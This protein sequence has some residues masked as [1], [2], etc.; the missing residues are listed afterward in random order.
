MVQI[1]EE[2]IQLI[3]RLEPRGL[4]DLVVVPRVERVAEPSEHPG[5]AQLVLSVA[6]EGGGVENDRAVGTL[7]YVSPPQVP[8][9]QGGEHLHVGK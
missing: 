9:K 2:L 3:P 4:G 7:C 5:D 1:V 8:V 6:I